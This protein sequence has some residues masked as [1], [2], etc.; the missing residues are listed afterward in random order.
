MNSLQILKNS[1]KIKVFIK[2]STLTV[3]GPLG[4]IAQKFDFP[5]FQRADKLQF[6]LTK[7]Q[8]KFFLSTIKDLFQS[9]TLG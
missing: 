9:I 7:I 3:V 1:K 6:F 4:T 2:D 5:L 8:L